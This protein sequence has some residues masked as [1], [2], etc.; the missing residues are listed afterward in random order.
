MEKFIAKK[1]SWKN[2]PLEGKY[3]EI[4]LNISLTEEELKKLKEGHIP[5]SM[6]DHW[7]TYYE[8][9]K[10]YCHRSWT[11]ICI[12]IANISNNQ[13]I[14]AIVNKNEEEYKSQ[15]L[16]K[17]KCL[18]QHLIFAQI[19]RNKEAKEAIEKTF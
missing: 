18:L 11:G 5:T 12:F 8:N 4:D 7:F 6:E 10:Y 9:N 19:G 16:E 1:S 15:N 13:V 14:S 2:K 17:D 3:A